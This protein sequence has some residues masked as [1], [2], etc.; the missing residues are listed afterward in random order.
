MSIIIHILQII[1]QVKFI[2]ILN[3]EVY[4][5]DYIFDVR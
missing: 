4:L 2:Y 5:F 1:K 3:F